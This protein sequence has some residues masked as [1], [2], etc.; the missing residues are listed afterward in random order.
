MDTMWN[1]WMGAA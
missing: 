1:G